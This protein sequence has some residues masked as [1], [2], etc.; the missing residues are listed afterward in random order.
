M[1]Q[2]SASTTINRP[3]AEV[4]AAVA[5]VTR[6]GEWSPEE[7]RGERTVLTESFSHQSQQG[8]H[9]FVYD[10]VAR[11]PNVM[12]KGIE[13]TLDRIKKVLEET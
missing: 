10:T 8:L 5:D 2:G 1:T 4:F 3:A 9:K 11:R 6:M 12:V 13:R 7:D